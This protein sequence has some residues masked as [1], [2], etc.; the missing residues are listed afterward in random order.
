MYT[1]R[2][3]HLLCIHGFKGMGYSPAFVEKMTEIVTAVRDVNQDFPIRVVRALDDTC[4]TCPHH[5]QTTCEK[6]AE[7]NAH[8]LQLDANVI[9]HLGLKDG[10]IYPKSELVSLVAEKVEPEDLDH[11]CQGCSWLSYGVCKDGIA[12]LKKTI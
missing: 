7:S 11:L 8:V 3:H 5:G 2:G 4:W 10:N 6:D 12:A 1:L 9:G